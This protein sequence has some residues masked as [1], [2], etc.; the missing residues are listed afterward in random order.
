MFIFFLCGR[1]FRFEK[2]VR[3][4]RIYLFFSGKRPTDTSLRDA[5]TKV[6]SKTSCSKLKK[7]RSLLKKKKN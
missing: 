2:V 5:E 1:I 3:S 7:I 4:L 6:L